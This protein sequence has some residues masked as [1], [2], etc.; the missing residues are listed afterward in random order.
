MIIYKFSKPQRGL[1]ND[2]KNSKTITEKII[3]KENRT[4]KILKIVR[5]NVKIYF[6]YLV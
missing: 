2:I 5:V 3:L 6:F 1:D 4:L